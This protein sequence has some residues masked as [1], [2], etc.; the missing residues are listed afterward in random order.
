MANSELRMERLEANGG[1]GGE[2]RTERSSLFAT[3]HFAIRELRSRWFFHLRTIP[4]ETRRAL[5]DHALV[6]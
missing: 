3:R 5:R 1:I 2:W 6:Y 4:A